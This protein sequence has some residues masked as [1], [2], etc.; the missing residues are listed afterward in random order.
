MSFQPRWSISHNHC[1]QPCSIPPKF[2][3]ALNIHVFI[4]SVERDDI[5]PMMRIW[6]GKFRKY[7]VHFIQRCVYNVY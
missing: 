6:G 2:H 3:F 7:V 1:N 4:L 5:L